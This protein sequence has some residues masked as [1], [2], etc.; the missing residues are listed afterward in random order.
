VEVNY[1]NGV[2]QQERWHEIVSA[3]RHES[4]EAADYRDRFMVAH[5]HENRMIPTS[6]EIA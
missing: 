4:N 1:M 3:L 6:T 5:V 2:M